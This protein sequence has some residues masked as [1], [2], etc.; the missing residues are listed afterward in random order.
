[1]RAGPGE[2]EWLIEGEHACGYPSKR[3]TR[4]NSWWLPPTIIFD[5]YPKNTAASLVSIEY[6][7]E[8]LILSAFES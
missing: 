5:T 4:F 3:L 6:S 1:M 2:L 8:N 7:P